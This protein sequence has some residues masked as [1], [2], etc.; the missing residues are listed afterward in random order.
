MALPEFE[1][2]RG[3]GGSEEGT[4]TYDVRTEGEGAKKQTI[5]LLGCVILTVTRERGS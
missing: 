3:E 4:F 5:A 1:M 2:R